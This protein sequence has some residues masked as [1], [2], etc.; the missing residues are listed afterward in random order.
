MCAASRGRYAIMLQL[1]DAGASTAD[2]DNVRAHC[3]TTFTYLAQLLS[4]HLNI[5]L[6]FVSA[7]FTVLEHVPFNTQL[8]NT[9]LILSMPNGDLNCMRTLVDAGRDELNFTNNVRIICATPRDV[10]HAIE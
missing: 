4:P 2:V 5:P 9:A 6:N 3:T 8:G 7:S 1:L 10:I